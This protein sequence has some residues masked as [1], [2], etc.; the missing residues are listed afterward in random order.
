MPDDLPP[1]PP[2]APPIAAPPPA[3]P[4]IT[5]PAAPP[6]PPPPARAAQDDDDLEQRASDIRLRERRKALKEQW[7]TSDPDEI[8]K[9]KA[10]RAEDDAARAR[11]QEEL[12]QLR[13]DRDE[14]ERSKMTEV[15]R[16]QT[17]LNTANGR[18][19]ELEGQLSAA[20]QEALS[21]RQNGAV[22]QA[23]VRHRIKAKAAVMR[24]VL[25]E[26]GAYYLSLPALEKRRFADP[27]VAERQLDRWMRTF[28]KENPEM[29]EAAPKPAVEGDPPPPAAPAAGPPPAKPAV[30][31]PLGAPPA[32]RQNPQARTPP[33]VRPPGVDEN[34]KTVKPGLPNSMNR[35]ELEAYKRKQ[36]LKAS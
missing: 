15:E 6:A 20:K 13:A 16:L 2:G 8:E 34:G 1:A 7:G 30:R 33:G 35:S 27:T 18:I 11:E 32:P 26:F 31:R 5:P 28:A 25:A 12:K 14:R 21:E 22:K 29:C 23:A 17:D 10:R 9:I 3:A 36:G 4:V 24:V 19:K